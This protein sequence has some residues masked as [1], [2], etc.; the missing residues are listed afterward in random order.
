[1]S[2]PTE[3][4]PHEMILPKILLVAD[5]LIASGFYLLR[6]SSPGLT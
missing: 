3:Q 6:G 4:S 2:W 5:G 1:M